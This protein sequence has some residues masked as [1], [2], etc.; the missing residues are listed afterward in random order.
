VAAGGLA[1]GEVNHVPEEPAD[2]STQDMQNTELGRCV[3]RH[4]SFTFC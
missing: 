4:L 3:V 1:A 2:R